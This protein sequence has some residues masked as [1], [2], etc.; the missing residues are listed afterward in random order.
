[1]NEDAFNCFS[2]NSDFAEFPMPAT[3]AECPDC[4]TCA[5]EIVSQNLCQAVFDDDPT[6]TPPTSC[7]TVPE[8]CAIPVW[9]A[10]AALETTEQPNEICGDHGFT[11]LCE[12]CEYGLGLSVSSGGDR[13]LEECAE[14]AQSMGAISF[15]YDAADQWNGQWCYYMMNGDKLHTQA[16][17]RAQVWISCEES[18]NETTE[19]PSNI[20]IGQLT[21][22]MS[23]LFKINLIW[24]ASKIIFI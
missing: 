4:N 6:V 19:Q 2:S 11:L 1:M 13:S 24:N 17:S 3:Y 16:N 8:L 15:Q 22:K 7:G 9:L 23:F 21:R 5:S 18:E 20:L 10:C 12:E 14:Y